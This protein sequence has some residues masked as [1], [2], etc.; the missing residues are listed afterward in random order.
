[1]DT[2]LA[3]QVVLVTGAAGGI[4]RATA[5]AFTAE[6]ARLALADL[7][8]PALRQVADEVRARG[9]LSLACQADVSDEAAVH[10]LVAQVREQ[11]GQVD[12]LVN[13]AGIF[14]ST[15]IDR[16]TSAEWDQM[17]AVNLRS[18]LLCAQAVLPAMM[19][20]R[21]G[22]IINVGSMAGQVGGIKA[23]AH[24]AA[25][26]AGIICL[27]K[28]LAKVAGPYGITV[29]CVNPGVID[30]DMT[31]AWPPEWREELVAQTPLRR[32]GTAEEVAGA[33]LFLAS[34]A[35]GFVHGAQLDVNGGLHMA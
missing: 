30:T 35:A 18:A 12:I 32:L 27:T 25:S 24:Y 23:G 20:R 1:M 21:H 2:G 17:L 6:G 29:N 19:A 11:I 33:I 3:E 4:G 34:R 5:L 16:L 9:G 8:L 22:R 7:N 28:S 15:P 31:R 14:R 10:A 13:N 26:K